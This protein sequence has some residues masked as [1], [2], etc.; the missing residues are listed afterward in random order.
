MSNLEDP[1]NSLLT[2][3][4]PAPESEAT[5]SGLA[6][7]SGCGS[8][9]PADAGGLCSTPTCRRFRPGNE[10]AVVLGL[11]SK[12]LA[13]IVDA[14]RV[15]LIDQ[16]FAERGGRDALSVVSR[17]AI[18]NYA[19]VCAQAKT[20]EERLDKDG[21]FTATGRRRSAF[22]M[23]KAISETIDRLRAAL[24]PPITRSDNNATNQMPMSALEAAR[25]LL[26]RV[27]AGETLSEREQGHLDVLLA[28]THG[29]VLLPP[30]PVD[31]PDVS[32]YRTDA[33]RTIVEPASTSPPV[34]E[35]EAIKPAPE[36]ETCKYC[37]K[38]PAACAGLKTQRPDV[39]YALHPIE[40][41][42]REDERHN[43][44][45]RLATGLDPW[46]RW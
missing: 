22:D 44:E 9:L 18:E 34:S 41:Q 26:E 4:K 32:T 46:P 28:A 27:T 19:L 11:R 6:P 29:K 5:G 2:E 21:L 23:L 13:K 14:Y 38:S 3:K 39:F 12:K 17:I 25:D 8:T 31:V 10:A 42:K 20:I 36:P 1:A 45:F 40:A 16:L 35:P 7:C 43:K 24:P 33:G 30:D 37:H 15:D